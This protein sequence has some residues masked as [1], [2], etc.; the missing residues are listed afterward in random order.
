MLFVHLIVG[1]TSSTTK[2][3]GGSELEQTDS[4][5]DVVD[6]VGVAAKDPVVV[7]VVVVAVQRSC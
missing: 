7:V 2:A 5:T 4:H 3:V 6:A 1:L